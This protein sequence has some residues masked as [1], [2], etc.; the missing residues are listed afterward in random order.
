MKFKETVIGLISLSAIGGIIGG[1]ILELASKEKDYSGLNK[2]LFSQITMPSWSLLTII[3]IVVL[4]FY[5]LIL[6]N[7]DV[8]RILKDKDD[9]VDLEKEKIRLQLD[10]SDDLKKETLEKQKKYQLGKLLVTYLDEHYPKTTKQ[11]CSLVIESNLYEE[12]LVLETISDLSHH[13][14]IERCI[15]V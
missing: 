12:P 13:Q 14:V 3:M 2:L 8:K 6:K 9:E 11:L 5:V 15:H 1:I 10:S 4:M 7:R